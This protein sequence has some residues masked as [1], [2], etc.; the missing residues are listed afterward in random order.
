MWI[1]IVIFSVSIFLVLSATVIRNSIGNPATLMSKDTNAFV[2]KFKENKTVS[3]G[4]PGTDT[5]D[6]VKQMKGDS[7]KPT[8]NKGTE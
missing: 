5:D 1:S 4:G 6:F 8:T 2:E 3:T 7:P